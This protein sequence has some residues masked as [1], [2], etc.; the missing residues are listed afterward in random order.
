MASKDVQLELGDWVIGFH[1]PSDRFVHS[2]ELRTGGLDAGRSIACLASMPGD[3]ADDWPVDVPLQEVVREPIG[4]QRGWVALGV[5]KSGHGHWSVAVEPMGASPFRVRWDVACKAD[6][7]PERLRS[8]LQWDGAN[9]VVG[10]ASDPSHLML[11]CLAEGLTH[12]A[13]TIVPERGGVHWDVDRCS[14]WIEPEA[15]EP[16]APAAARALQSGRPAKISTY[17]WS[18]LLEFTP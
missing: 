16:D 13:V 3:S 4:N 11:R 5:G 2:I 18:Y 6:R 17:R 10:A 9:F 7:P 14:L 12:H 1:K 15:L 8:A